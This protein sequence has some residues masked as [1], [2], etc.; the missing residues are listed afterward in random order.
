MIY[1]ELCSAY[2]NGNYPEVLRL[3][4]KMV[5][6]GYDEKKTPLNHMF[7]VAK[8]NLTICFDDLSY[9]ELKDFISRLLASDVDDKKKTEFLMHIKT[10]DFCGR[11]YYEVKIN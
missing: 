5:S 10:C 8:D 7:W 4:W 9:L 1:V 6:V 11:I 3:T 2:E